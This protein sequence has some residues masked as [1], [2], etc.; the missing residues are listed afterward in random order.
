MNSKNTNQCKTIQF[1]YDLKFNVIKNK[2]AN[3]TISYWYSHKKLMQQFCRL[4]NNDREN[5]KNYE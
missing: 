4:R 2:M 1:C 5:I 3:Y